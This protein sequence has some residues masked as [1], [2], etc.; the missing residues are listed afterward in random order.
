MRRATLLSSGLL[1]AVLFAGQP[2]AAKSSFPEPAGDDALTP[3]REART[4]VL[5]GGC[6]W[7]MEE[8]FEHVR[9]VIDVV[10][11]YAGGSARTADYDRVSTGT[12]G[13]A[14]SV[15]IRYEASKVTLG[16]LLQIFFSVAHDPTQKDRQGPDIGPQYRS[17]VFFS[18]DRQQQLARAYITQLADAKV[19]RGSIATAVVPLKGFYVAEDYHQHYAARH[20]TDRYIMLVDKPKVDALRLQFGELYVQSEAR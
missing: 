7:G 12:T 2:A 20:P 16:Q 11:G 1:W 14:E 13:H 19:F 9:G 8:V 18:N 6:F 4:I 15:K 5:A 10:S 17:A 3:T